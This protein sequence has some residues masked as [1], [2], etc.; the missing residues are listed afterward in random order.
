MMINK[1]KKSAMFGLDA[2]IA[3]AIFASL[4]VIAGAGLYSAIEKSK[5]IKTINDLNEIGKAYSAFILDTRNELPYSSTPP[6]LKTS[7]LVL[8]SSNLK[9]WKGPYVKYKAG[10]SA[11]S[12]AYNELLYPTYASIRLGKFTDETW[13][14][15]TLGNCVTNKNCYIWAVIVGIP[16]E[17]A[18]AID[19]YVDNSLDK[20][21]GNIR[22]H[23]SDGAAPSAHIYLKIQPAFEQ[24]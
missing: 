3:L 5:I 15:L 8:N 16:N 9:N 11:F 23:D 1:H 20:Q 22:I 6:Y 24:P 13:G 19:K 18:Y 21:N 14:N 7:D 2:R 4:S 10:T 17:L 12:L